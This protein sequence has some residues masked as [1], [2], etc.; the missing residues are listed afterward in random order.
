MS[1]PKNKRPCRLCNKQAYSG[2]RWGFCQEHDAE[3]HVARAR[4][5]ELRNA[6]YAQHRKC[7]RCGS[8]V[9][10]TLVGYVMDPDHPEE[11][12]DENDCCC[13]CGWEGIV[14]ELVAEEIF[15]KGE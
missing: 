6:Y 14:H 5:Q 4:I 3:F 10:Q 9:S 7:P 15:N 12:K 11:F 1:S 2:S 8:G 13:R